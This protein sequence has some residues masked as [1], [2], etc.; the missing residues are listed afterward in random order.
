[1]LKNLLRFKSTTLELRP[2]HV[3]IGANGSGRS[4]F[5][6]EIGLQGGRVRE[7]IWGGSEQNGFLGQY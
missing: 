6:E 5:I 2:L 3:L 7:W 4:N 1:M